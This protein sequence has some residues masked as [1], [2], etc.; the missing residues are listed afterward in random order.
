[1]KSGNGRKEAIIVGL[2]G[3]IPVIWLAL[4][5]AP[6]A[7]QGLAEVLINSDKILKD[8]FDIRICEGSLKTAALFLA[9]YIMSICIYH[10][11]R[12]NYRKGEEHGSAEWGDPS[13][14]DRKYH[15]RPDTANKLLTQHVRI[16]IDGRKHRRNLNVL[17]CGG[18][19][20]GK[21]RFYC[22][23]NIMQ[24]N[25]SFVVLDPKGEIIRDTGGL[26][27]K[28]G[29]EVR[30]L[31]LINM[32]KSHC[33]NP[34]RYITSDNDV[35]KLVT[36]LFK[37]TTPKG[38]Q[39][40]D[41]FWDTA[42]SML[43][44]A[45]IFYLKY[46]APEEEQN[47]PMVMEMLRAGDVSEEDESYY[48]PLDS[49]FYDLEMRQPDHIA[50]KYY[51]AY[52]SGSA[53]TLKSIQITLAARLE[54]FNLESMAM[55]TATDELDLSS[56][57]EK[58]VA[59]FALIPDNDT[60]FNFLVSILYTQLFQQLFYT[61]DRKYGGSLPVH[62]HFCMDEF[63]NVSLPDDFDKILSVM[64]S[65][66]VSVSI[67]LQN[68]AQLKALFEKQWESIVGN[69]DEF[70]YLGG[71]EQSTHKY[72]SELLGKATIDTNTYGKSSGRSGNY[73]TNYQVAGRELMTP[74][75]VRMLDNRY[76]LL[77]IRGERPV[78]DLKFDILKHQFV[79]DTADGEAKPYL[80]GQDRDA[81]A[82]IE[83]FYGEPEEEMMEETEQTEYEILSEE[84]LQKLYDNESSGD[85]SSID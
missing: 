79:K 67:I 18:S 13:A 27:E 71:N 56:M 4:L 9:V 14:V 24:A 82:A 48:S 83:L 65:R 29:Y 40:S 52:H 6:F 45:L 84:E 26:L 8:P 69:C 51:K 36:N 66:G 37:S 22:K 30:V 12:R 7:E 35:Q 34:F 85:M 57:G 72:V 62:V 60:S 59:L 28:K 17:V 64:R 20:A 25:T 76:A 61:A 31:D 23:P 63:S 58:K 3:C 15:Q 53:K 43:L 32:E 16:G 77:F 70:L 75:E 19:G 1:M 81:V 5:V 39:S 42:A 11:S 74:D 54:K 38:S 55:L 50:V 10:T 73:S 46:E 49:L 21:T 41:P 68:M 33:Y 2:L 44:L 78:K 47:F 80:H